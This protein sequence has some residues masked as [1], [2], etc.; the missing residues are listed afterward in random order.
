MNNNQEN[1][2]QKFDQTKPVGNYDKN[3]IFFEKFE[4]SKKDFLKE[5]KRDKKN[6]K[7]SILSS[8]KALS[9]DAKLRDDYFVKK[10]W[11]FLIIFDLIIIAYFSV[12][13][14]FLGNKFNGSQIPKWIFVNYYSNLT[15]TS[16]ILSGISIVLII[17]PYF[18]LLASWFIGVNNIHKSKSL[19]VSNI[20]ILGLSIVFLIIIIPSSSLIF[21]ETINYLPLE[22]IEPPPAAAPAQPAPNLPPT[23]NIPS[24]PRN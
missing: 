24:F 9:F 16:V 10:L 5:K 15:K 14:G 3:A 12:I 13:E 22:G 7:K 19:L 17:C 4:K 1:E 21:H 23:A 6:A 20:F 11:I 8:N 2:V 18:F